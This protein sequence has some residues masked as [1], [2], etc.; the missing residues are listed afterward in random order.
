MN[1]WFHV[2]CLLASFKTQRAAT[3]ALE[4]VDEVAGWEEIGDLERDELLDKFAKVSS[5]NRAAPKGGQ[6]AANVHVS[7]WFGSVYWLYG[8]ILFEQFTCF[9]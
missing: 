8:L 4:S 2:D 6:C 7:F 5:F 3:K 9:K 1:H